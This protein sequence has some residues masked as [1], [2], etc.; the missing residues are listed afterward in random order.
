MTTRFF[1]KE[2]NGNKETLIILYIRIGMSKAG[3]KNTTKISTGIK[4]HP[5]DWNQNTDSVR[6]GCVQAVPINARLNEIKS[7]VSNEWTQLHLN[8]NNKDVSLN[9]LDSKVRERI[10]LNV[11]TE[12]AE[13]PKLNFYDGLSEFINSITVHK[14]LATIRKYETL[15]K[16]LLEFDPNLTYNKINAR[17][18][19]SITKYCI[20]KKGYA[21]TTFN[22]N[23]K[24]LKTF[25]K[26]A[27]ERKLTNNDEYKIYK[28]LKEHEPNIISL[29]YKEVQQML[30]IDIQ[31][32]HL[33]QVRDVFCFACLTGQRWT[34]YKNLRWEHI[35]GNKWALTQQKGKA[36]L[37][38]FLTKDCLKILDKYKDNDRP[39]PT[40]SG[41]KTN[42]HIKEVGKLLGWNEIT[43]VEK[44]RGKNYE[45]L[46]MKKWERLTTHV[47]RKTCISILMADGIPTPYIMRASGHKSYNSIKPYINILDSDLEA[48]IKKAFERD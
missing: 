46:P 23:M 4:V 32:S 35:Q 1:L 38:V 11:K 48:Y 6:K 12:Y 31:S 10:R 40:I 39:L 28:P 14:A 30:N 47:A 22:K 29:T 16:L 42:K 8:D 36:R 17:F 18:Y 45:S 13:N 5:N 43:Y 24:F 9:R 27:N 19:D 44:Y 34:D 37:P 3:I 25:M 7:I 20:E 21:N 15:R 2:A 33:A 41:Q 26:W